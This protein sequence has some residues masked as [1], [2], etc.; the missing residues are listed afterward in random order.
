M[1]FLDLPFLDI[2]RHA[3]QHFQARR[4]SEM[5]L[6]PTGGEPRRAVKE[7]EFEERVLQRYTDYLARLIRRP[8]ERRRR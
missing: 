3:E 5:G 4:G 7:E 8:T 2:T 1:P 6:R